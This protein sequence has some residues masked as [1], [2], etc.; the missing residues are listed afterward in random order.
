MAVLAGLA[1]TLLGML[2]PQATK[3]LF[4]SAVP[5]ADRTMLVQI[6]VALFVAAA[7][8]LLFDLAQAISIMRLV[9]SGAATAQMGIWDRLL[10]QGPSF[11]R[12]FTVGDIENRANATTEI[13]FLLDETTLK[14]LLGSVVSLLNL[15]LLFYYSSTLAV[16][17]V[18]IAAVGLIV[19]A[20]AGYFM[21]R[22]VRP[23]QE[24][25]G[26]L[27][28]LLIQLINAVSKIRIAGAETRAF[29][30]WGRAYSQKQRLAQELQIQ[31]DRV[32]V[33]G[34]VLSPLSTAI[35]FWFAF[36]DVFGGGASPL[37]LG[38][39]MAF[40]A[41][42]GTFLASAT[43]LGDSTALLLRVAAIWQRVAPILENEPELTLQ[44]NSPGV[45]AGRVRLDHV[46]F[47]YRENGPLTLDD[48]TIHVDP[49]EC[50]AIVGP[51]GSGKSTIINL[52]LRFETPL[53][54]AVYYDEHDLNSL[55]VLAVRRQLGV[56]TQDNSIQAGSIYDNIVCGSISTIENAWEAARAAGFDQDIHDMPMGILTFIAE[57]GGNIS[58]G[59][60]QR[61]LI[62]RALV[63]KP[64]IIVLDEATSALDNRTQ[65]I[66]MD[67]LNKLQ[68]T[69][70]LVA[71][72]LSTVRQADRIY[73]VAGGRVVQQGTFEELM[74]QE[75]LFARLMQRQIA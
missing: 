55:D 2:T 65:A 64:R 49:G 9:T 8:S 12:R 44:K 24:L 51:S 19:N 73:V 5:D 71:H 26:K 13:R 66:V 60:R 50:I 38:A 29:A 42:F 74:H 20:A 23:L 28:G 16:V 14:M 69:R 31:S 10:R 6:G 47:R 68:V 75:G 21:L 54:G 34:L 1:T 37:T 22:T 32:R 57:G 17:A 35:L 36:T 72:R 70:I 43:A 39:F 3:V 7:G 52:L 67:S 4:E 18:V 40:S 33:F 46:T 63:Q 45:L 48:V 56:V 25:E 62:A 30:Q 58:G 41:A 61:L 15:V 59:Q 27:R 53:T 11:F